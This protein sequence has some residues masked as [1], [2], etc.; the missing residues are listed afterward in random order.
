MSQ[1]GKPLRVL[2]VDDSESDE[3]LM[4][5]E[6]RLAGYE[7]VCLRVENEGSMQ[8]ALE[9]ESWDIVICDYSMPVF[10]PFLALEVL[11]SSGQKIPFIVLSGTIEEERAIS[12]IKAGADD[13]VTKQKMGRLPL[14]IKREIRAMAERMQS[15]FN[16]QASYDATIE[17][18]GKAL[19]M[20][21]HFTSG[22]TQRVTDLTMRL[23]RKL[24]LHGERF[25]NIHRGALLHDIGKMG[26]PDRILLKEGPL[27][28]EERKEMERHPVIAYDLLRS[29]GFLKD[30][31]PIPY[32]H[33]ERWD[34]AGY[35]Q[36]LKEHEIPVEARIFS[37]VDVFD[38]L[39][40]DRPYR[41]AWSNEMTASYLYE[42]KGKAFDPKIA[43]EFI[44]MIL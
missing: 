7:S 28:A 42:Q 18:W 41:S 1:N 12:I 35:P 43:Q 24:G 17:A 2:F 21:D 11:K 44:N 32:C 8:R 36:R 26:I 37:V 34:G 25:T 29:I 27:T 39:T 4:K 23:A 13:F 5:R 22:H 30:A 6:L 3:L 19:E 20:R 14:A 10:S 31:I 33:H 15:R 38:A 40:S 9:E 16:L